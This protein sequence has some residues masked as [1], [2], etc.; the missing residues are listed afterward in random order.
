MLRRRL[1]DKAATCDV[2]VVAVNPAHTSQRC[3][4]CGHTCPDNRESQAVFGCQAC[5]HKTNADVNAAINI[6]DFSR[7]RDV[8]TLRT[9]WPA[10]NTDA[11][12]RAE[13]VGERRFPGA[14]FASLYANIGYSKIELGDREDARRWYV[15]A[16]E[17]AGGLDDDDYGRMVRAGIRRQLDELG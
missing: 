15:K 11:L 7:G 4:A 3:A 10:I 14:L 9:S 12:R 1:T 5:G 8:K 13:R 2:K 17:A 6:L 16:E